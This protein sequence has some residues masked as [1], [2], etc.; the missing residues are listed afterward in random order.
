MQLAARERSMHARAGASS[1]YTP[2]P[3]TCRVVPALLGSRCKVH[4]RALMPVRRTAHRRGCACRSKEN[5]Q[6]H[7]LALGGYDLIAA[8][9]MQSY[10]EMRKIRQ[11]EKRSWPSSKND[12]PCDFRRGSI[13]QAS[14]GKDEFPRNIHIMPSRVTSGP[15]TCSSRLGCRRRMH[16]ILS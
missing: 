1:T 4:A 6:V 7:T 13:A 15:T 11:A 12:A 10:H 14:H 9:R 2:A 8:T 16:V 3:S 5:R